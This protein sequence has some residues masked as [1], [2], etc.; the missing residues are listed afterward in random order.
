MCF[1]ELCVVF[2]TVVDVLPD[3]RTVLNIVQ[4]MQ[5]EGLGK[6]SSERP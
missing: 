6:R 5:G 3:L 1:M 2:A 4:L